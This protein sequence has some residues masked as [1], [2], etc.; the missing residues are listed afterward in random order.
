MLTRLSVSNFA[1]IDELQLQF[2]D[3]LT[4]I[5]GETGAGKSILL[6]ALKLVLGERAD[7][8]QLN[9]AEKKCIIEATFDIS[10]LNLSSFFEENELDHESE[11]ILRRELLP[12][13]KSRAFINDTPVTLDVLQE[14]S[15]QLIDIHS[16]FST[17]NL[18]DEN[19]QMQILDAYANQI[20]SVN[21]YKKNYLLRNS[22]R[23]E[24]KKLEEKLQS[25]SQEADY[26]NFLL[27]ELS[28][29]NLK[30]EE[31]EEL[32]KEQ[33]ELQHADEI[34]RVLGEIQTKLETPEFG[35]IVQLNEVLSGTQRISNYTSDLDSLSERFNSVKIEIQDLENEIQSKISK[36]ELNPE[37]LDEVNDRIN[38]L[39]S[40]MV[41]HRVNS[42][43]E[44]L[45]ILSK[46]E[47]ENSDFNSIEIQIEK[48]KQEINTIE[49][50][51]KSFS[52]KISSKR[53]SVVSKVENSILETLSKLGM[54]NSSINIELKTSD[55]F[56]P[57]GIDKIDM[58]FTANKGS[59][60]KP[61]GKSV[62]GGE[63]SRLMLAIKKLLSSHLDLPTLILDEV[64]TGVSGKVADEVGK[65]MQEMSQEMQLIS[66][67]HLPQVAAKGQ[68]HLKVLKK[69]EYNL[70]QTS[71]KELNKEERILEIAEL[72]S[73]A[74]ISESALQQAREL[75][76]NA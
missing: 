58:L 48:I 50:Q 75:L 65:L 22:K 66:I 47:S 36:L 61:I 28:E 57:N 11:S 8:K 68:F 25:K 55:E 4:I 73:G 76:Q 9:N 10:K 15:E 51:L 29:S 45:E 54:E 2:G 70:T 62:S 43:E 3:G 7:L 32:E 71:V 34:Q 40:L 14:L 49:N 35:I 20:S 31:L 23:S 17:A 26:Q 56:T 63:R 16:Q 21:E 44:L 41:K 13:G 18:L 5:T 33:K 30:K 27:N 24:L 59:E 39:H 72:I 12:S 1:I 6:G 46:L 60:L 74:S 19:Y 53:K 64:D 37:R 67:T 38:L 69:T 52:E 42:T